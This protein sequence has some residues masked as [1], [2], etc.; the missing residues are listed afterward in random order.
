MQ[1]T[2]I[3]SVFYKYF[4]KFTKKFKKFTDLQ[5]KKNI[6]IEKDKKITRIKKFTKN[7]KHFN[8]NYT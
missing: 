8:K 5:I 2:K 4:Q 3:I 1:V 6:Y 7:Y